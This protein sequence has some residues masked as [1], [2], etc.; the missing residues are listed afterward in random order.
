MTPQGDARELQLAEREEALSAARAELRAQRE[1][2]AAER[3]QCER[4]R[5]DAKRLHLE[6]MR[7]RDR[8]RRLAPRFVRWVKSRFADAREVLDEREDSVRSERE[9]LDAD[10]ARLLELQSAFHAAAVEI[11]DRLRESWST[12]EAQQGRAAADWTE[13]ESLLAEETRR[14]EQIGRE[15]A[16]REAKQA[17]READAA[18]LRE[19]AQALDARI[20]NARAA[21]A[22]IETR[23]AQEQAELDGRGLLP[24]FT[25]NPSAPA[26]P[27]AVSSDESTLTRELAELHDR[28]RLLDE[29]L[30]TLAD[31]R[32]RWHSAERATV[33]ELEELAGELR[34]RE[35][36]LDD[37]E[38]RLVHA[39]LRRRQDAY[40]LWQLR[41]QL[42]AWQSKLAAF[43]ARRRE[44]FERREIELDRRAA[45]VIRREGELE[46]MLARWEKTRQHERDQL[47]GELDFWSADRDRL[48]RAV[49]ECNLQRQLHDAELSTCAARAMAA[50]EL[51][52]TAMQDSG[53]DRAKRRL[54]VLR[55]R[56]ERLFD[57]KVKEID[58][59][60]SDLAAEASALAE[61]Y[62]RLHARLA[63]VLEREAASQSMA[64]RTEFDRLAAD[65]EPPAAAP[66]EGTAETVALR[67]ELERLAAIVLTFD[68]PSA[69]E[70]ELPWGH[71]EPDEPATV[72]QF[73]TAARAA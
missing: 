13:A 7:G 38:H 57:R 50:E 11:R 34:R 61:R 70:F 31:A 46:S 62:R 66:A 15:L 42:E 23:R 28:K 60:R 37:R 4:M 44:E 2:L 48:A 12:V 3:A 69:G 54:G 53:S 73:E 1:A 64:A 71:E 59:R 9:R 22:E 68:P 39:D 30:A 72:F 51:V 10:H 63:S 49:A 47:R 24:T 26:A 41:L 65:S 21:L 43:E 8:A 6:A 17:G 18:G 20:V 33:A 14:L 19:E 27:A 45:F 52:A 16:G 29:Q 5:A 25:A 36:D 40:E 35:S 55:K 67:E 56:W 32:S 58:S